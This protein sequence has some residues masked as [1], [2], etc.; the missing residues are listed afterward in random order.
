M[1]QT[2]VETETSVENI[3]PHTLDDLNVI[4]YIEIFTITTLKGHIGQ[5]PVK[6][7]QYL[8]I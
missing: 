5:H 7:L 4:L 1:S 2:R 3:R 8:L 6:W